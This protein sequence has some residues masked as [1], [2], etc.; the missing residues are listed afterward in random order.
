MTFI[1]MSLGA[2]LLMK[3]IN[4]ENG[5]LNTVIKPGYEEFAGSDKCISCHRNIYDTHVHTAHF[6]TSAMALEKNIKGSFESEKNNFIYNNGSMISMEKRQGG[7]YQVAYI[8]GVEKKSQR[9]DMVI[10]SGTKGQ[11]YATWSN[12]RLFQLP[13]TYFTS[14]DQWCN[15]PGYP[16]K[17][18]FNRPI[19]SRCLE[20]HS[21]F[22]TKI[23]AEGTEPEEFDKNRIILSVDCERCHGPAKKHVEFQTLNPK[24]TKGAF[25]IN[26][27]SFSRQQ[28]LDLCALCHGGRLQKSKPSFAF[29]AGDK[30][31]DYFVTDT[32]FKDVNNIDVH[33]NQYGLLVASKCFKMS[34]TLTCSTCHNTHENEKGNTSLFSQRCMNCHNSEHAVACKMSKDLGDD[35]KKNCIDCH[36]PEQ[37]SMAIAVMLK[38]ATSP[39][40]ALMRTHFIKVY[41]DETKKYLTNF[42]RY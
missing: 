27:A 23:T 9:F 37:P 38:G 40:P 8:N 26:P 36:M 1:I 30:L 33:G 19:T 13:I 39:T 31:S 11:S 15:S 14:A 3:C 29:I 21:T 7:M 5:K 16:G 10:G 28:N 32:T 24:E 6:L 25:I 34:N 12:N 2:F 17:I 4:N 18:A 35:I 20:C 41:A 22:A 42:K